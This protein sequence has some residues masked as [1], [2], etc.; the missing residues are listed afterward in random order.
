MATYGKELLDKISTNKTKGDNDII[1]EQTR[2]SLQGSAIGLFLGLYIG[3]TR[4]YNLVMSAAVGAL[5]GGFISK[6]FITKD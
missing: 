4:N 1:K 2:G 3:H 6:Y 5:L